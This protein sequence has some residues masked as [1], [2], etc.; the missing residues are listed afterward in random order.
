MNAAENGFADRALL[1][2]ENSLLFEQNNE[3]AVPTSAKS[4]VVGTAR[5]MSYEDIVEAQKKR[6]VKEIEASVRRGRRAKRDTPTPSQILGKRSRSD[7]REEALDEIRASGMAKIC[8]VLS[9]Q[10]P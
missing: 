10:E 1:L 9:L 3:K 5:V 8:S 2:E 4:T 6:E 7:E